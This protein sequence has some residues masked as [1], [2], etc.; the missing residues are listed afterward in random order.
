MSIL[1]NRANKVLGF[2]PIQPYSDRKIE[3][4]E[5]V[6]ISAGK[7]TFL[8][9][10]NTLRVQINAR[11]QIIIRGGNFMKNNKPTGPNKRTG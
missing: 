1:D 8:K 11:V 10:H 7:I 2:E 6:D 5:K 3:I 9:M 4:M